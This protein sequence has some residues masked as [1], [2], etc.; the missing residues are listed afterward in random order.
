[1]TLFSTPCC[2]GSMMRGQCCTSL[3]SGS[4]FPVVFASLSKLV[5]KALIIVRV[6]PLPVQIAKLYENRRVMKR[7]DLPT[8]LKASL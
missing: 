1:M 5:I 2:I 3:F 6:R 8:A 4:P 7:P